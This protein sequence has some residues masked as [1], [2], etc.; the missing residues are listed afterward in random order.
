MTASTTPKTCSAV[1]GYVTRG[2]VRVPLTCRL[3]PG[4]KGMHE[5][6]SPFP[7]TNV[8]RRTGHTFTAE[9]LASARAVTERQLAEYRSKRTA[10]AAESTKN[11]VAGEPT[12]RKA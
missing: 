11:E 2:S 1:L 5:P 6:A 3:A 4:H 9:Q 8:K 7:R 10:K 12:E